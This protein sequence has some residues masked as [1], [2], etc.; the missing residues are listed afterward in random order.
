LN[1]RR[2][3]NPLAFFIPNGKQEEYLKVPSFIN[4]F[5]TGNGVGK[6]VCAV[7]MIGNLL[8]GPQNEWFNIPRYDNFPRPNTGRIISTHKNIEANILHAVQEWLP[9]HT[10]MARK[11]GKTFYSKFEFMN[12]SSFDLMTYDTDPEQFE[13]PTLNWIWFD[14]PPPQR[15]FSACVS[16]LRKGGLI[17]ITMTP[18]Y[19][20]G[21]L[22]DKINDPFSNAGDYFLVTAEIE[23]NCKT[24]GIRG[25]L[26]H[27]DIERIIAEY[28]PEEKAA[29]ISGEPIHLSGRI[30]S[31][32]DP[33][34]HCVTPE[35]LPISDSTLY[36]VCDPHDRKPFALG[37]YVIDSTG[38][39]YIVDE[40]PNDPYHSMK[41]C[42]LTIKDY[43]D[44]INEKEKALGRKSEV[45]IID[46]RYGNRKSVQTGDTIRD[47]FDDY[48]IHFMNSYTD[49]N[50]SILTGHQ[51]IKEMLWYDRDSEIS[52]TNK[53]K[54]FCSKKCLNHIYAFLHYAYADNKRM[55]SALK[56]KPQEKYKDFMDCLRYFVMDNPYVDNQEEVYEP[57]VPTSWDKYRQGEALTSYGV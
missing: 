19:S 50:A 56:E 5:S 6:T 53:P 55:E 14:E 44:I 4:I 26:N 52:H 17:I 28:P 18:L 24:H 33:D 49:E 11:G 25:I 30:F 27:D 34:V 51:R 41:S 16:R 32:F 20:G 10:Y 54:L 36:L 46:A 1:Q 12:G 3:A 38:D 35:H 7:N 37:W 13:G 47:E 39:A 15:I 8:M 2:K 9:K 23:D 22:F 45:R 42:D 43:V 31:L 21:W 40:W 29:R 48:G 57:H